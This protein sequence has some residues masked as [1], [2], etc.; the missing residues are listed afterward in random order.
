[1]YLNAQLQLPHMD[2]FAVFTSQ[3]ST[4][5]TVHWLRQTGPLHNNNNP[6]PSTQDGTSVRLLNMFPVPAT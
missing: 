3:L 4:F 2:A 5:Q 1:M 6:V